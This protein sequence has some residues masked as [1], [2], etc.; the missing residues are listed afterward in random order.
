[1]AFR[2]KHRARKFKC[3]CDLIGLIKFQIADLPLNLNCRRR[4]KC[5][6]SKV[7]CIRNDCEKFFFV[8]YVR[9]FAHQSPPQLIALIATTTIERWQI[10][11]RI[12]SF[13]KLHNI[14]QQIAQQQAITIIKYLLIEPNMAT[15]TLR[16]K[17]HFFVIKT[18][19]EN[20]F[21]VFCSR[22]EK[23]FLSS[24]DLARWSL[25]DTHFRSLILHSLLAA[26]LKA[27]ARTFDN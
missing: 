15:K 8:N 1:M 13:T 27:A 23:S 4:K 25:A 3:V 7:S 10:I 5:Q 6:L 16:Q 22:A 18:E 17:K 21:V 2:D 11:R 20:D 9:L 24:R 19:T 26:S 14:R 12:V